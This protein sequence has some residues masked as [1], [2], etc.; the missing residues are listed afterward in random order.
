MIADVARL[1]LFPAMMAFAAS[2]DLLTMTISNRITLIL[3]AGFAALAAASGM[4][5]TDVLWHVAAAGTV[6]IFAFGFFTRG[7][8]GGGDAKLAAATALWLGFDHL[9]PYLIYASLLGGARFIEAVGAAPSAECHN[10]IAALEPVKGKAAPALLGLASDAKQPEALR[11]RCATVHLHLGETQAA[12]TLL[13]FQHDPGL[14]TAFI[15]GFGSW[16]GDLAILPQTARAHSRADLWREIA[17][18]AKVPAGPP[19]VPSELF[20]EQERW[21]PARFRRSSA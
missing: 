16:H 15:L 19:A 10:I 14:R 5:I 4:S 12:Q 11:I 17:R 18:P 1:M 21:I 9:L 7:W 13:A 3:V 20:R 2:S 8:I 6:L